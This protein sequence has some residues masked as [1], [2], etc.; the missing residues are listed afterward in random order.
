MQRLEEH[1]NEQSLHD[2]LQSA[3]REDHSTETAILKISNDTTGS[4]DIG[5]C[6][7]LASN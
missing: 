3:Y 6:V 2:P 7:V 5:G 1:L 4:L